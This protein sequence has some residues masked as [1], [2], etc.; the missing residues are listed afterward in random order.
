MRAIDGGDRRIRQRQGGGNRVDRRWR[1]ERLV[2]LDVEVAVHLQITET[3]GDS[4][5]AGE[6]VSGQQAGHVEPTAYLLNA[7]VISGDEGFRD[8]LSLLAALVDMPHQGLV[9][10]ERER[11]SGEADR[12]VPAG[13]HDDMARGGAS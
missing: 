3:F 7:R 6:V 13:D 5:G 9:A 1:D 11:L 8:A 2:A 12:A 10:Q 4:I